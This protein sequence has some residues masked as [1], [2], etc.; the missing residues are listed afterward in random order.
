MIVIIIFLAEI[1]FIFGAISVLVL[2]QSLTVLFK[3]NQPLKHF[4]LMVKI[5]SRQAPKKFLSRL[6]LVIIV[7]ALVFYIFLSAL[8]KDG[9]VTYNNPL[10]IIIGCLNCVVFILNILCLATK[11]R[12]SKNKEENW[13]FIRM[14]AHRFIYGVYPL[15]NEY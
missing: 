6:N 7:G 14:Q 2:G 5:I 8:Q 4:Y 12:V 9:L 11:V 10:V 3:R 13:L 15:F 1:F